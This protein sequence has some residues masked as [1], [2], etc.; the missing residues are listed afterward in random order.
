MKPVCW[1]SSS[2]Q[3]M[4]VFF[5]RKRSGL[6]GGLWLKIS[7]RQMAYK[8]LE[9][10]LVLVKGGDWLPWHILGSGRATPFPLSSSR[11]RGCQQ[12]SIRPVRGS[13]AGAAR[14]LLGEV[15]DSVH[16]QPKHQWNTLF[17]SVIEITLFLL[18]DQPPKSAAAALHRHLQQPRLRG[19]SV[20]D[21]GVYWALVTPAWLSR[22][23][24]DWPRCSLAL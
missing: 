3:K 16:C 2:L 21:A 6:L 7:G 24:A 10:E 9:N 15:C 20:E 11:E 4:S 19:C 17:W 23:G 12:P 13:T 22:H 1:I 18:G 8:W 14:K 5:S